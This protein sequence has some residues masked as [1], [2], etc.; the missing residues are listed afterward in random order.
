MTLWI[1]EQ[2]VSHLLDICRQSIFFESFVDMAA[3]LAA[4]SKDSDV[5][6]SR[7]KNRFDPAL[8]SAVSAGYRN[9]AVNLRIV[10]SETRS[11]GTEMHVCEVQLLLLPMAVIKVSQNMVHYLKHSTSLASNQIQCRR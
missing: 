9:L 3:C 4:I 7:I 11:L 6:I 5:V 8:S 10:T 2:D 1:C